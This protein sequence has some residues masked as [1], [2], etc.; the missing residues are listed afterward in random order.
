M[1]PSLFWTL[2]SFVCAYALW[3]GSKDERI[4][5]MV[6]LGASL[7]TRFLVSPLS[8][9]YQNIETGLVVLDILVFVGFLLIA[10]RSERFWPLWIAGLQ[11]TNGMSHLLKAVDYGLMPSAYAAA[12]AFWSYPILVIIAIGT[13]RTH[14]RIKHQM[15]VAAP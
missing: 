9:R 6:C 1:A 5:A 13:F 2:L 15:T 12:A 3:R 11:L 7:A 10:L 4:A 8:T 14:R